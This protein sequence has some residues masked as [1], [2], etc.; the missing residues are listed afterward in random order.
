MMLNK[1]LGKTDYFPFLIIGFIGVLAFLLYWT[2]SI[3]LSCNRSVGNLL[4]CDLTRHTP[5]L[6]MGSTKISNPLAVDLIKNHYKSYISYTAKLR[7]LD[8]S[9]DYEILTTGN[10][11]LAQKVENE[12]NSFLLDSDE[13]SFFKKYR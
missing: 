9:Y 11:K 7:S 12:I 6:R 3:E 5:L 4:E 13:S 10:Y 2:T 1:F 8:S